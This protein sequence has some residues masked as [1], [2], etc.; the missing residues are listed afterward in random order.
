LV[1]ESTPNGAY[2]CF[3][4]EW[5][6]AEESGLARHFLPWWLESAYIAS[7]ATDLNDEE[8]EAQQ[9]YGLTAEQIGFRRTLETSYRGLRAQEFAEDPESCFRASGNC[10]FEIEDIE[11]RLLDLEEPPAKRRRG[12]LQI[13]MPPVI[14]NEYLLAVDP[15]GGGSEGDPSAIQVIELGTGIQCAELRERIRPIELAQVAAELAGEYNGAMIVVERNNHGIG[16]HAFLDRVEQYRNIYNAADGIEGFLT[17]A[18]SKPRIVA[19]LGALLVEQP[20]IFRSRRLLA[21]CRTFV[22]LANGSTGAVAGAHDDC[23]MAMAIAQEVRM[24]RMQK[25]NHR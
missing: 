25:S 24:Q 8:L 2:G 22:T 1:L 5:T 12:T 18:A 13:W 23:V 10:C 4:D 20:L 17:T 6:Q 11:K 15:A 9:R 16:V 19:L 14:G 7:A 21:E 3:Y